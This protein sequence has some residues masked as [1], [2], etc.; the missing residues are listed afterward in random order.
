MRWGLAEGKVLLAR[1]RLGSF[2]PKKTGVGPLMSQV[3]RPV[4]GLTL[5]AVGSR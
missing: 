4:K 5:P 2:G 1:G 3:S